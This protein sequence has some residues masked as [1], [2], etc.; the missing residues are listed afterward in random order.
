MSS[1]NKDMLN[2]EAILHHACVKWAVW[3]CAFPPQASSLVFAGHHRPCG[4]NK[5]STSEKN[6]HPPNGPLLCLQEDAPVKPSVAQLAGR[7]KGHALP[8]PGNM[9]VVE[10]LTSF[11][12]S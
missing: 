6:I 3:V 8:M 2:L 12:W 4:I 10:H 1:K 9:E 11:C 7:L 5:V